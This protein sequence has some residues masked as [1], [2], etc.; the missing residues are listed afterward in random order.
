MEV[1]AGMVRLEVDKIDK[2][3]IRCNS[4]KKC[5]DYNHVLDTDSIMVAEDTQI[6]TSGSRNDLNH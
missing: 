1:M 4:H 3:T 5:T 2:A 6:G